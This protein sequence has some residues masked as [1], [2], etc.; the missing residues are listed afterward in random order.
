MSFPICEVCY[1]SVSD[2]NIGSMENPNWAMWICQDCYY[3]KIKMRP[4]G[5]PSE[6]VI[7]LNSN[8][9]SACH[10]DSIKD[11]EKSSY[12]GEGWYFYTETW[13]RMRGPYKTEEEAVTEREKFM[14]GSPND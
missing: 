14:K 10:Y 4:L 8:L 1:N 6:P 2:G 5:S 7:Y 13:S 12:R 9:M 3:N 11:L